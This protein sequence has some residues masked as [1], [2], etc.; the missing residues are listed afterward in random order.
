MCF[1]SSPAAPA[2]PAPPPPPPPTLDQ[3]APM[4]AAAPSTSDNLNGQAAGTKQYR[5]SLGINDSG[6]GSSSSGLGIAT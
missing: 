6:S 2:P 4:K 1:G 5:T 3:T